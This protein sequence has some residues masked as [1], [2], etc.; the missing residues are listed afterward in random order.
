MG[1]NTEI[2]SQVLKGYAQ[3]ELAFRFLLVCLVLA[4][5][6]F[7]LLHVLAYFAAPTHSATATSTARQIDETILV[8][9]YI[10]Y[11]PVI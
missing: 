4:A 11:F 9:P 1:T 6:I 2:S 8:A 3:E 10:R 7:I 5:F